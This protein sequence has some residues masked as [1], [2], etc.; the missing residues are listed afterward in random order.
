MPGIP[1]PDKISIFGN[2]IAA[3]LREVDPQL[4]DE[5]MLKIMQVINTAKRNQL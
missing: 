1:A 4:V 5:L 3:Q 2:L